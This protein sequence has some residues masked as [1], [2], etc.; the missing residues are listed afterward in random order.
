M[1][2]QAGECTKFM[3]ANMRSEN[4][5][6]K[7]GMSAA[8]HAAH[9]RESG[10]PVLLFS[11]GQSTRSPLPRG[12]AELAARDLVHRARELHVQ[13]RHAARVMRRQ[14]HL[15]GLVDVEPLRMVIH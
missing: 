3:M 4:G 9:S 13:L 1:S 11:L 8:T 2:S 5:G 12:R 7:A 6:R 14:R 15:D 10:N